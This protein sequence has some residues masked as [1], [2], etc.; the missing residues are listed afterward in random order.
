[1]PLSLLTL[2]AFVGASV[3]D[4]HPRNTTGE[5]YRLTP[6]PWVDI[7]ITLSWFFHV[8]LYARKLLSDLLAWLQAGITFI[9]VI[10]FC[11]A[12]VSGDIFGGMPRRYYSYSYS[13]FFQSYHGNISILVGLFIIVQAV[14]WIYGIVGLLKMRW[15]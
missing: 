7:A 4:I 9:T 6:F 13:G 12:V 15:R 14:F 3:L 2:H 1:M 5:F 8:V 10:A 11:Y